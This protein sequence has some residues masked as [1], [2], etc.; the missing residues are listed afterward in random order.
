MVDNYEE[1]EKRSIELINYSLKI[2][3]HAFD[4]AWEIARQDTLMN[5]DVK[6]EDWIKWAVKTIE[7]RQKD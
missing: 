2:I 7:T 4:A 3:S 6:K 5:S 1:N